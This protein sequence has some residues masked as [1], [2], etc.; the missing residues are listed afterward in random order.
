MTKAKWTT[1]VPTEQGWYWHWNGSPDDAPFVYAVLK[2]GTNGKCFVQG[3][4][5]PDAPWCE[6]IGGRWLK[7]ETPLLPKGD[8]EPR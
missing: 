3:S 1:N 4:Y 5:L 2:S 6:D 8:N 7:I